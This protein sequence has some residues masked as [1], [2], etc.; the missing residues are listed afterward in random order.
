M[1]LNNSQIANI[2]KMRSTLR[3]L[4]RWEALYRHR[5]KHSVKEGPKAWWV[6]FV[7]SV[8]RPGKADKRNKLGW[9]DVARLLALRKA[10]VR[11]Y[12]ARARH[13]VRERLLVTV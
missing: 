2:N 11:L 5:P 6:F 10:Y 1:V 9:L 12:M 13:Q 4:E 3:D 8:S 7:K